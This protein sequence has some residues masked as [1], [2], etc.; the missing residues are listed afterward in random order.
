MSI[1]NYFASGDGQALN[2]ERNA[3][4][5]PLCL[6]TGIYVHYGIDRQLFELWKDEISP[7]KISQVEAAI[8]KFD[9]NRSCEY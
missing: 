2:Y 5:S 7:W 3:P 1:W 9:A 8:E 4:A 6:E